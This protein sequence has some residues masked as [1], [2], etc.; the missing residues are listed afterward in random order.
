MNDVMRHT[1]VQPHLQLYLWKLEL[2]SHANMAEATNVQQNCIPV[3]SLTNPRWQA[4]SFR[5]H[6]LLLSAST[7]SKSNFTV[8]HAIQV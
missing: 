2:G 4:N 1:E 6:P 7:K 5:V 3:F 8:M